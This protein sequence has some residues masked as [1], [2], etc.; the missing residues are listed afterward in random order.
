[1]HFFEAKL[2]LAQGPKSA[3]ASTLIQQK[4]LLIG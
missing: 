3:P 4:E 1:M 2:E